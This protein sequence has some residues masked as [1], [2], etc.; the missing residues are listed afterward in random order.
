[1]K[2]RLYR[3][4]MSNVSYRSEEIIDC[5][6]SEEEWA[7]MSLEEQDEYLDQMATDFVWND[8]EC[9]AEIIDES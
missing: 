6:Y 9:G 1:M 8:I 3:S 7:E 2:V 5:D 4:A